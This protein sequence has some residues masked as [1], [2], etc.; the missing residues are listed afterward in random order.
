MTTTPAPVI[1]RR[2]VHDGHDTLGD[3]NREGDEY[4]IVIDGK[5]VG[6]TYYC[7]A[8]GTKRNQRWASWGPAGLSM[9]HRTRKDAELVQAAAYDPADYPDPEPSPV[10]RIP[11][12]RPAPVYVGPQ[13]G[14][15]VVAHMKTHCPGT[16]AGD[17]TIGQH[18]EN[19][20]VCVV[21]RIGS[22]GFA[23]AGVRGTTLY[24]WYRSL[25]AAGFIV[26]IREDLEVFG[27][28][29]ETTD[30]AW[31]LRVTGHRPPAARRQ[32]S[33]SGKA[34]PRRHWIHL[35]PAPAPYV[36][37]RLH[38]HARPTAVELKYWPDG[39]LTADLFFGDS[40]EPAP[41]ELP[42]WLTALAE[43][44]RPHI[45]T[46]P[47]CHLDGPKLPGIDDDTTLAAS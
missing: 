37:S 7:T 3:A 11:A 23:Q 33:D 4:L 19:H 32:V 12:Q 21:Y 35:E 46:Y 28:P 41:Q 1:T 31:W 26:E 9:G 36:D 38:G 27:R 39:G 18:P 15:M 16:T 13:L 45:R 34:E 8:A 5:D 10:V 30:I 6:G 25:T 20:N 2:P 24:R 22:M 43:Q 29:D 40:G 14:P 47:W 17:W 42:D 44:H